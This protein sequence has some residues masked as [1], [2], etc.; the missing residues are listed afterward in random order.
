MVALPCVVGVV[1]VELGERVVLAVAQTVGIVVAANHDHGV[2]GLAR[3]LQAADQVL[4]SLI[5]LHLGRQVGLDLVAVDLVGVRQ[6]GHRVPVRRGHRVGRRV[7]AVGAVTAHGHVVDIE[8]RGVAVQVVKGS[9]HHLHVALG[10]L[11]GDPALDAVA[12]AHVAV[13]VA[14]CVVRGPAVVVVVVAR[15]L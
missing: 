15:F 3:L 10:P 1:A 2:V 12:Q 13:G 8:G 11:L 4:H 5:Q 7:G 9:A 14:E 6:V